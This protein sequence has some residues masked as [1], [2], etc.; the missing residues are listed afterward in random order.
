MQDTHLL[1]RNLAEREKA[2]VRAILDG[3][4]EVGSVRLIN[5]KISVKALR[6]PL[7]GIAHF[8]KPLFK[9]F[10][11]RW[12]RRNCPEL[13]TRWLYQQ[14]RFGD[15]SLLLEAV[16]EDIE[17]ID[18]LPTPDAL[19]PSAESASKDGQASEVAQAENMTTSADIQA[20]QETQQSIAPL[21]ERQAREIIALRGRVSWLS[22]IVL[23]LAI[24]VC[25]K[26]F[27]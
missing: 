5:K 14:V 11:W 23:A 10:A 13:I 25:L 24:I 6:G 7:K 16:Q 9:A 27:V 22:T 1:L 8:S 4:Y 3:L 15:R 2:T 19:T 12:F 26:I 21:I 18:V 17:P 20:P